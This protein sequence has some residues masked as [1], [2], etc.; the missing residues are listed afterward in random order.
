MSKPPSHE[1][2]KFCYRYFPKS[3]SVTGSDGEVAVL[4]RRNAKRGATDQIP[5]AGMLARVDPSLGARD[6]DR[7]CRNS[8]SGL[9]PSVRSAQLF[10]QRTQVR[11][12]GAETD[13][14][15]AIV[16]GAVEGDQLSSGDSEGIHTTQKVIAKLIADRDY[17]SR[18]AA[19]AIWNRLHRRSNLRFVESRII[20]RQPDRFV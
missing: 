12:A 13:R 5:T 19:T 7:S 16:D 11:K 14:V 3:D 18:P 20:D 6:A 17:V 9:G 10:G 2:V 1:L 4:E 8:H 15:A